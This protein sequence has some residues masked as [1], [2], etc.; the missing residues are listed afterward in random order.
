[1]RDS[2]RPFG[3]LSAQLQLQCPVRS[4]SDQM[5]GFLQA[6][7]GTQPLL[8]TAQ[9]ESGVIAHV[10]SKAASPFCESSPAPQLS[11]KCSVNPTLL[12]TIHR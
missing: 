7:Q 8:V 2:E 1:M 3:S 4:E 6:A 5:Q 9:S 12:L 11:I 10:N